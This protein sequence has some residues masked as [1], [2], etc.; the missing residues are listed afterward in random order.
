MGKNFSWYQSEAGQQLY[1]A[2]ISRRFQKEYI[3]VNSIKTIIDD[4][5]PNNSAG[6]PLVEQ[7]VEAGKRLFLLD[8][9]LPEIHDTLKTGYTKAQLE[10]AYNYESSIWE[11]FLQ[12]DLLYAID[13][14][15]TK[16]YMNDSPNTSVLGEAS[17]GFI[18][19]FV[20]WQ[21]VKK[22]VDKNEKV[23]LE[24]LMNTDAKTIFEQSKY[25][26]K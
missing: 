20:G 4:M 16:D 9:L 18:G 5:Y 26:P 11:F 22:W 17:P 23:T 2:Y 14:A 3:S 7:M 1:P 24:Q 19:Q 13:P 21:I 10:G 6:K 25:K 15:L 12:N 8:Y